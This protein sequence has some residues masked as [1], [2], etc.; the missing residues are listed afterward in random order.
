MSKAAACRRAIQRRFNGS[1]RLLIRGLLRAEGQFKLGDMFKF[2]SGVPQSDAGAAQWYKKAAE[3]GLADAQIRLGVIFK[4]GRGVVQND[5]EA[6]QWWRKA[7]DQ[8]DAE[9]QFSLG[10]MFSKAS[11][12]QRVI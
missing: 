2:G 8:G 6:A 10:R 3:Q 7:A 5:V 11:A 9:A 1:K 4:E 12:W